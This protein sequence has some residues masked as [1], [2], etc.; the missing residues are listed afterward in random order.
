MIDIEMKKFW[1]INTLFS[2]VVFVIFI[3]LFLNMIYFEINLGILDFLNVIFFYAPFLEII[4]IPICVIVYILG[5]KNLERGTYKYLILFFVSFVIKLTL[6]VWLL[7][8]AIP[9][10][11]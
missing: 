3:V 6:Y 2:V 10:S 9:N 11:F 4:Q 5:F 7:S 1:R 8:G